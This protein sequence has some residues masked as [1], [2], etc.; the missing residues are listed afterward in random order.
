MNLFEFINLFRCY[1][2][3]FAFIYGEFITP[4]CIPSSKNCGTLWALCYRHVNTKI[5]KRTSRAGRGP[6][7]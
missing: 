1:S 4:N 5:P 7:C 3:I 6:A 2:G